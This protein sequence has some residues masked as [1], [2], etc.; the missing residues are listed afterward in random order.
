V[1]AQGQIHSIAEI[2][3]GQG[4]RAALAGLEVSRLVPTSELATGGE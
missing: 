4:R 3:L 2:E 1:M